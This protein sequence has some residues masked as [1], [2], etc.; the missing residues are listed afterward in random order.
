M[1]RRDFLYAAAAVTAIPSAGAA[2]TGEPLKL[3]ELTGSI[4]KQPGPAPIPGAEWYAAQAEDAAL[5]YTFPAGFLSRT[6]CITT[7][8][9]LDGDTLVVFNIL[10]DETGTGRTFRYTFA[11]LNQCSFRVRMP[12]EL[13][14]LNRWMSDREGAFLKPMSSG[15]RVDLAKVDRLRLVLRRKGPQPSRWCMTPLL[16]SPA[17][18]ER[19]TDPVLPKGALLDEFG[20]STLKSWPGK[21]TSAAELATRIRGQFDNASSRKWPEDFTRWGGWKARKLGEASGFF[22]TH[23]DGRRWWLVDPDGYAFWSTG[24]DCVRV[25]TEARIDGIEKALKWN[26]G[27]DGEFA[28]IYRS[29][30]DL[31]IPG[32]SVNFLAAN[33]IRAFGPEK[34]RDKWATVTLAE[35]KR[36]RFNTVGNWSEWE[37]ARAAG[38]PYVRPLSFSGRHSGMVYRDFPDVFHPEF[39]SDVAVYAAQ[40]KDT[41]GDPALIGYFLMNE[42]TWGFS[43]ETPAAGMLFNTDHCA[44]RDELA[45]FLRRKYADDAALGSAWSDTTATFDR[46]KK[47]KWTSVLSK[48]ALA[49]LREFSSEMS[50]RYFSTLSKYCKQADPNHL[51][52][53]MRWA[54]APPE[55][56]VQGMKSFDVFSMNCYEERLPLER[57]TRIHEMVQKPV[58]VGE[59]HFGALDV[60]LPASGIG[61]TRNQA[62]R[63][64]AYRNYLEDAAADPYCVGVHWF[65]LYDESALGRFDGENYNIGFLD[66]CNRPYD[67]LCQAAITSHE[68]I[69]QVADGKAQPYFGKIDYLPKLFL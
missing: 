8:M 53:G 23:N 18:V 20:Q 34:W 27:P 36:L 7:D 62:D 66:I 29:P 21:T 4:A 12:L 3:A 33:M 51:N 39:E 17:E 48:P 54:G 59:W 26:P 19:M 37:Y 5:V 38:F 56:A 13:V 50:Q 15:D 35:M 40:L 16:A 44:T 52:L 9:L 32:S 25:D 6:K 11:G 45:R 41:A 30:R 24:P 67:E 10:L 46:I 31:K 28:A 2:P 69:H 42:P 47:G 65:T 58:L 57:A 60:G 61:H 64:T 68:R 1:R 63:G 14:N 43:S 55:W 22:R 49:D